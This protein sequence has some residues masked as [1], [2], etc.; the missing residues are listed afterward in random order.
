MNCSQRLI[1]GDQGPSPGGRRSSQGD[2]GLSAHM[3][4]RGRKGNE[5]K[6]KGTHVHE[7]R[8]KTTFVGL[9]LIPSAIRADVL[10]S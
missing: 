6:G 7:W 8:E 9:E 4:I 1:Q 5:T 3:C 2:R 10:A